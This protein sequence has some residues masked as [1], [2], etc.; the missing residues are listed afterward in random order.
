MECNLKGPILTNINKAIGYG[1]EENIKNKF[2]MLNI[3]DNL[4]NYT[5]YNEINNYEYI[6][7]K[8][9]TGVSGWTVG[10]IVIVFFVF[11]LLMSISFMIL[12]SNKT[13]KKRKKK[14][15]IVS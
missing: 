8:N 2:V 1:N 9:F 3:N 12:N 7:N 11:L 5:G 4:L 14:L 10:G 13:S 6:K 15:L